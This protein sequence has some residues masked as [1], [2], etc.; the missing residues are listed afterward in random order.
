MALIKTYDPQT[1]YTV[2]YWRIS[3][4]EIDYSHKTAVVVIE[5]YLNAEARISGKKPAIIN[6]R[7]IDLS[8]LDLNGNLRAQLYT[9]IKALKGKDKDGK[10]TDDFFK[11]STDEI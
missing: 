9:A 5:G 3:R 6:R 8:A 2:E 1:G 7:E 10:T 4:I 11:D